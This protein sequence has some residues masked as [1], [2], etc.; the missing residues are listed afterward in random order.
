MGDGM[1]KNKARKAFEAWYS[2][3]YNEA[4]DNFKKFD[5]GMYLDPSL[6]ADWD[7]WQAAIAQPVQPERQ[8]LTN[9]QIDAAV[10]AWFE[11]K[12]VAG[13]QPFAKRMRAAIEA[14]HGIGDKT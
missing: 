10:E 11:N 8:P 6:N 3:A 14:A 1:T 13:R 12:I 7:V 9:E 2:Q 5:D 4:P